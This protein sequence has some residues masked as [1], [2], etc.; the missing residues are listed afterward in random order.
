ML[1]R[2]KETFHE[3]VTRVN[4]G[5]GVPNLMSPALKVE[6]VQSLE[7]MLQKMSK[8]RLSE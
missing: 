3:W 1:K 5:D 4:V 6:I 2:V 7:D 8:R